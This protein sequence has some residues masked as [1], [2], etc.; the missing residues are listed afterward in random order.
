[1]TATLP[2]LCPSCHDPVSVTITEE[3]STTLTLITTCPSC[4]NRM[5]KTYILDAIAHIPSQHVTIPANA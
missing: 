4:K 3:S 5:E 1:M 2:R